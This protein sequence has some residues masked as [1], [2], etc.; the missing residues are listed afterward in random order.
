MALKFEP[1]TREAVYARICFTGPGGS[2]KTLTGLKAMHTLCGG[3]KF[4]VIDTE[5]GRSKK[6]VGIDGIQFDIA[7]PHSFSP[8]SLTE[9]LGEAAGAGYP[10]VVIDGGSPYWDGVDGMLEQVD[11]LT[12]NNK[13]GDK[14]GGGWREM[15]PA[16]KRMWGAVLGYPGHII[17]TLRVKSAYVTEEKERDGRT[18]TSYRKVG[19]K[20]IQRDQFD[21]EFDLV[22]S[23][24][25]DNVFTVDKSDILLV[26]QGTVVR[27]PGP[28]FFETIRQFCAEGVETTTSTAYRA[29]A[30]DPEATRESLRELMAEVE[31]AG[32]KH[33]PTVDELDRP[34]VLGDM[35]M[36]RGLALKAAEE[37]AQ[38]AARQAPAQPAPT[39]VP[40]QATPAAAVQVAAPQAPQA[41]RPT[42]QQKQPPA[43]GHKP[44][45]QQQR[46][47]IESHVIAAKIN[48]DNTLA[49][50]SELIDRVV[51]DWS[52][53]TTAEAAAVFNELVKHKKTGNLDAF[54]AELLENPQVM[55]KAEPV[56]IGS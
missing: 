4:A 52:D 6:Y 53:V 40:Q 22:L 41:A 47:M 18:V 8:D 29:R 46:T 36:S 15:S 23:G 38:R 11:R 34:T 26:P 5:K 37:A 3:E 14:F 33:T 19:L 24:D 55:A 45:N 31:R 12:A 30:L 25:T 49:I 1:A 44:A 54:F 43:T 27:K 13:R 28:E 2:G 16:E 10:G 50:V 56:G 35:I 51:T 20:P 9:Q 39:P 32:M 17:M 42:D 7:I 48:R 21:Y